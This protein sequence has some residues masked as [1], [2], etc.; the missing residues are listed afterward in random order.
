MEYESRSAVGHGGTVTTVARHG[1]WGDRPLRSAAA[2]F[3]A[4]K[5]DCSTGQS[6]QAKYVIAT[7]VSKEFKKWGE[8]LESAIKRPWIARYDRA[9]FNRLV[10]N[11]RNN[12]VGKSYKD[13]VTTH[14]LDR[15]DL[16]GDDTL[17]AHLAEEG[18]VGDGVDG[19]DGG[20]PVG[21]A[22]PP[23]VPSPL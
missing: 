9:Q 11:Y 17:E 4:L 2:L 22:S 18:A 15:V 6:G 13:Y 10:A 5:E 8:D 3:R 23:V 14:L 7:A 20:V 1:N 12:A 21:L 19:V 16:G